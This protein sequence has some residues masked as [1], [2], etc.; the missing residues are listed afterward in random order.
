MVLSFESAK[1]QNRYSM[2]KTCFSTLVIFLFL[3]SLGFSRTQYE[4]L[5]ADEANKFYEEMGGAGWSKKTNWPL[6]I[7]PQMTLKMSQGVK[8]IVVDTIKVNDTLTIYQYKVKEL[9]LSFNNLT[10]DIPAANMTELVNLDLG[11]NEITGISENCNF[12]VLTNLNL[13][14]NEITAWNN[15]SLPELLTLYLAYNSI[16]GNFGQYN[17]PMLEELDLTFNDLGSVTENLN[18]PNLKILRLGGN[19]IAGELPDWNF[20]E[21]TELNLSLNNFTGNIHSFS[22][23]PNLQNLGLGSNQLSGTIPGKFSFDNSIETFEVGGNEL[24]GQIPNWNFPNAVSLGMSNNDLTG[25]IPNFQMPNLQV[26][27]I[28][29]TQI[30][31]EI[32]PFNM[33][34]LFIL[35]LTGNNLSGPIPA[36]ELPEV[37]EIYLDN[38]NLTGEIPVMVLPKLRRLYGQN[39]NLEGPISSL[40]FP[41][42]Y[43]LSLA[44]NNLSGNIGQLLIPKIEYLYL[45]NNDFS[46]PFPSGNYEKLRVMSIQQND[47]TDLPNFSGSAPDFNTLNCGQNSL[48]FDDLEPYTGLNYFSYEIQ[49]SVDITPEN[50]GNKIKLKLNVGGSQNV[51]AWYKNDVLING[52]VNPLL[53]IN[54]NEDPKNYKCKITSPL[55]PDLT[56]W[57]RIVR[58]PLPPCWENAYFKLCIEDEDR[59]WSPGEKENEIV[60]SSP[61]NL[62]ELIYFEGNMTLDTSALKMKIDGKFLLKDIPLPGGGIGN[63]KLVEGEYELQ[64]AGSDGMITGFLNNAISQYTPDIG[65]LEIKIE[66]LALLGGKS[67]NGVSISF[68]I[69]FDNI[70]P[71]CGTSSSQT[72]SI[73]INGLDITKTGISVD[74]LEVADLG[75]APG[76]CLKELNAGYNQDMDKL[77]FGLTILTPFIEIGGGLGFIAGEIDSISMKAVL[78]ENIIPIGS[79]GIGIIGCEGRINSITNPPWNMRF[80]GIF[81]SVLSDDLF[82]LTASVEYIPPAELKIEAGDGKF[83]NP[84]FY[85]DWWQVEGGIYGSIDFRDYKMKIGG[86]VKLAPFKDGN[87]KK[88][89]GSGMIDM[90]YRNKPQSTFLGKFEGIITIPELSDRFPY[91]WL[92]S[93]IGLPYAV[94]GDGLLVYRTGRKFM[95]G[96]VNLGNRIGD[97]L[98]RIELGKPYDDPDFFSFQVKEGDISKKKIQGFNYTMQIPE[99]VNMAVFLAHNETQL[100]EVSLISPDGTIITE[101]ETSDIAELDKL[102]VQNKTFWT[103][104]EPPSGEWTAV[105]DVEANCSV[106]YFNQSQ[107]FVLNS[108]WRDDRIRIWW[109][110]LLFSIGD[111]IDIYADDDQSDFNGAYLTTVDAMQSE[112]FLSPEHYKDFCS[113]YLHAIGYQ[114][115]DLLLAYATQ[116]FINSY[117]DFPLPDDIEVKF[118]NENMLIE[119]SWTPSSHPSIAGY[120]I[121]LIKDDDSQVIGMLYSDESSFTYPLES[122]FG[123]R[124]QFQAFGT[125]GEVSCPSIEYEL[126]TTATFDLDQPAGLEMLVYP[127]P[128]QGI[129]KIRIDSEKN[130]SGNLMIYNTLGY[131]AAKPR[132]LHLNNGSNEIECKIPSDVTGVYFI[133][134]YAEGKLMSKRVVVER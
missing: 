79:T 11:Y 48:E 75:L 49:D 118:N 38:N 112:Y 56:L 2:K 84:P 66:D 41:E 104:Y 76:F 39:N 127:N 54:S 109:N 24:S 72:T 80:G 16:S 63:F 50:S 7:G 12:P 42:M 88:F 93:K 90:T 1:T 122:Y 73:K 74:G 68:S 9:Q 134:F 121:K 99:G 97:V 92:S 21:L 19:N 129:C 83:F 133:V 61:L 28:S 82:Q 69:A 22:G 117:I 107:G 77:T 119:V 57:S 81:S 25:V 91:D 114:E 20:P 70:T 44:Y 105:T 15:P 64:L 10:G 78:Q 51:Y 47:F 87:D 60:A 17:T 85:D 26:L 115:N 23:M 40:A 33:P 3:F 36:L 18:Y 126:V 95:V 98:Y 4:I 113:F 35:N 94:S 106:Y 100:P 124:I 116:E 96:N 130:I 101:S 62:N 46:G 67:A 123:Q 132:L 89:L 111:S 43:E 53:E 52:E 29:Y 86:N 103:I 65:G 8:Y 6:E 14:G 110:P 45:Q 31:G 55:L 59:G 13:N 120:V 30:T 108:E 32:P 128:M 34:H 131:I 71:S 125:E 102:H 37:E 5:D 58:P 27:T